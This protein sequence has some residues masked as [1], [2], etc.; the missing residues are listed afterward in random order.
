MVA[1]IRKGDDTTTSDQTIVGKKG[2]KEADELNGD[3][4]IKVHPPAGP[5]P[6]VS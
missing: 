4:Y 1:L 5:R 6:T 2:T 3:E